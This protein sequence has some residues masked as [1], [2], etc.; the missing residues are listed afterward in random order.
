MTTTGNA[1]NVPT[2][3]VPCAAYD[4]THKLSPYLDLHLMIR[5]V[6]WLS[7]Q[8]TEGGK[9]LYDPKSVLQAQ[10]GLANKTA[11]A[12]YAIDFYKKLY[13]GKD[14]PEDLTEKR[15]T[16]YQTYMGLQEK[17]GP[18][19]EIINDL[20][21]VDSLRREQKFTAANLKEDFQL[22]VDQI[23]ILYDLA[24]FQTNCGQYADAWKNLEFYV[25]LMPNNDSERRF[26]A[27][28]GMLVAQILDQQLDKQIATLFKLRDAIDNRKNE[29]LP[30]LERLQ[31]RTWLIHW[32]LFVFFAREDAARLICDFFF[33]PRE[34]GRHGSNNNNQSVQNE[35]LNVVQ[36]N[37]PWIL[38]Y[39]AAA[40]VIQKWKRNIS[41]LVDVIR[42]EKTK[43]SDPITRMLQCLYVDFD[44]T[45]AQ[46]E[47]KECE[48]VLKSDY[49]FAYQPSFKAEF[50]LCSR[51]LIFRTH[52]LTHQ[53]IDMR[54]LAKQLGMSFEECEKWVVDLIRTEQND[55]LS[56]AKIDTEAG[57]AIMEVHYPSI[58]E[59]IIQKTQDLTMRSYDL[60][61]NVNRHAGR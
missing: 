33:Q 51:K 7:K 46:K 49:F 54:E 25:E 6:D 11:M 28:W 36:T 9:A 14:A 30:P 22:E 10:F 52:C 56:D 32:S 34:V 58:Y 53:K 47:L 13:P 38:R 16:V 8:T 40:V 59:S 31:Q 4:L 12:D 44:I 2:S 48:S 41:I 45:G 29:V 55:Q 57:I 17:A 35:Y 3:A 15:A 27:L 19:F 18:V 39:L 20:D 37:C 23:E 26:E 60:V 24:K 43:Y 21:Q 5:I 50:V 1:S 42:M 61:S